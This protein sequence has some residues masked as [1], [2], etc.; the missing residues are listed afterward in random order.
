MIQFQKY[1]EKNKEE[2]LKKYRQM[3]KRRETII[4]VHFENA[5]KDYF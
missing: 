1:S 5:T 4:D 3:R 2:N